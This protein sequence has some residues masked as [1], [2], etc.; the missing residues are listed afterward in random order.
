MTH[1]RFITAYIQ[2]DKI[3]ETVATF[4]DL[5]LP[6]TQK[7]PGFQGA[8]LLID[9]GIDKCVIVTLWESEAALHA[10]EANGYLRQ[11]LAQFNNLFSAPPTREIYELAVSV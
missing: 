6:V 9:R 3:E 1:A 8:R 5:V 10:T 11:Q 4:R 2:P 7:Q